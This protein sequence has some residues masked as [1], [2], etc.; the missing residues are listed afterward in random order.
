MKLRQAAWAAAGLAMTLVATGSSALPG[1]VQREA[2]GFNRQVCAR[3]TSPAIA[4]CHAR[5]LTDSAGIELNGKVN[6]APKAV[7][8]GF[9]ALDLRAAYSLGAAPAQNT[10]PSGALIAIVDAYGYK[11]AEADLAVYRAQYGLPPCTTANGCLKI[12]DQNGGTNLP[13]EDTGWAQEAALDLD[14]ASAACPSCKIVLVQA[15]TASIAD[16]GTAVN[17]AAALGASAISNS[18]G[19]GEFSSEATYENNYYKHPG[20]AVTV[21]SGDNG[22]GAEFPAA[23]QYV[24]AVGGTSLTRSG[25]GWSESAWSGAGSGC[26]AYIAKPSWQNDTGCG[27]RTIADVS[28]VADP[29]TGVSVYGPTS[30]RGSGWMV[31]GGTSASAPLIAGIYASN[32]GTATYGSDPYAH[33]NGLKD[34][35]SGSNGSCSTYICK[36]GP[37]YDGPTGLGTP[38]GATAF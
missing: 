1:P 33:I 25:A 3:I 27:K 5:V 14:M 31:F 36:S 23:S 7:P 19:A 37:G 11:N 35:T 38:I 30:R 32:G 12:V 22:Y 28:A 21:S 8:A 6:A 16:L 2:R 10:V 15:R 13:R 24:T 29:Y 9:G 18:Y 20:I 4:H 17:T 34:V 26:S